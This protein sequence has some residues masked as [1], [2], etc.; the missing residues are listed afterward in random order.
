MKFVAAGAER[1]VAT[2]LNELDVSGYIVALRSGSL[3]EHSNWDREK[4]VRQYLKHAGELLIPDSLT[5][6][7]RLTHCYNK[8]NPTGLIPTNQAPD[9]A[10]SINRL[11]D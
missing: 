2:P 11:P 3:V 10:A 8:R 5:T 6:N 9:A 4:Y 7:A 1:R